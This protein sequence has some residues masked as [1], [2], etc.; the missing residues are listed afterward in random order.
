MISLEE[1]QKAVDSTK[2]MKVGDI[3]LNKWAGHEDY[4]YNILIKKEKNTLKLLRY[5]KNKGWSVGVHTVDK[6]FHDGT[7]AYEVIEHSTF[8]S[9]AKYNLERLKS[10]KYE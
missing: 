6:L 5:V 9:A 1:Y 10:G 8:V 2:N 4:K 7:P 3:I